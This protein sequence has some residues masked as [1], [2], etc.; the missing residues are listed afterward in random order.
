MRA[1]EQSHLDS[2]V[3]KLY[4]FGNLAAK[5]SFS[6]C[7]S[8]VDK[9]HL[10]NLRVLLNVLVESPNSSQIVYEWVRLVANPTNLVYRMFPAFFQRTSHELCICLTLDF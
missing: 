1:G 6:V 8:R 3:S 4:A 9:P 7:A 5:R 10:L 2:R